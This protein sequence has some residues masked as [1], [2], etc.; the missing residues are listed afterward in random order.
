MRRSR[1]FDNVWDALEETPAEA[2]SLR[3][4]S[5]LAIALRTAVESW[6]TTQAQAA[7]R[8]G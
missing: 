5:E 7:Q 4:R 6:G 1:P 2:A 3:L 8:P